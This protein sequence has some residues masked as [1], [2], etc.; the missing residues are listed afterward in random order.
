MIDVLELLDLNHEEV[1]DY[2]K[3]LV[4]KLACSQVRNESV[5]QDVFQDVFLRY[6][7]NKKK[8]ENEDHRKGWF[9]KVTINC[10][11]SYFT[12]TYM[13]R[14]VPIL[15]DFADNNKAENY[16]YYYVLKLPRKYRLVIHLF[17]YEELSSK[18]ISEFL[19]IKETTIRSQLKR[20]RVL[21]KEYMKE[22]GFDERL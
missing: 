15:M 4:Y 1:V 9:I 17:Y 2:Y 6:I 13:K 11:R 20:A 14:E 8:F 3:D 10:S 7:R 22:D 18:E 12:Q 21:L 19:K 5:A 16:I